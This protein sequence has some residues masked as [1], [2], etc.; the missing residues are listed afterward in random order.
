MTLLGKQIRQRLL[1]GI[2]AMV[3]AFA[4]ALG[5]QADETLSLQAA[6]GKVLATYPS[7]QAARLRADRAQLELQKVEARLG[8]ALNTRA[9]AERD[10]SF[11][12]APVDRGS[13]SVGVSR[14][15]SS[16]G[17][18]SL[19]GGYT[20]EDSSVSISPELPN[21]SETTSID[22][23]YRMPLA[24][25]RGNPAYE[26]D[27]RKA[28]AD[29]A[30]GV[31]E[32]VRERDTI[33]QQVIDLYYAAAFTLARIDNA[34]QAI[35]RSKRLLNFVK[36]NRR[37]GI[38]EEKD[39][40]QAEAQLRAQEAEHD[41]LLAVWEQQRTSLN[42][43]LGI[44]WN[45]EIRPQ[46]PALKGPLGNEADIFSAIL[47]Y[48]PDLR[49]QRARLEQTEAALIKRQ[50]S[51]RDK[52]DLVWSLGA[53]NRSGDTASG[54]VDDSSVVGGLALE[55]QSPLDQ[56]GVD[57]ELKQALLDRDIAK[58]DLQA[59][60]IFAKHDAS[61]LLS[62]I[63]TSRRALDSYEARLLAEQRKLREA[64]R[65]YREG[66]ADT[67]QLVQFEGDLRVTQL[68]LDQQRI[69]LAKRLARLQLLQ[70]HLWAGVTGADRFDTDS[71]GAGTGG[72]S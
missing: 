49:A 61:G 3:L 62:E 34:R 48:H 56:R 28:K 13:L 69:E 19:N 44:P 10:L 71:I 22:L 4:G 6:L 15:L 47:S 67:A 14:P 55:Y 58:Q 27:V 29:Q 16:G 26:Q 46:L 45:Q 64:E 42:S 72:Q 41:A 31:A 12:G 54:E 37:L 23:D 20:Q 1:H 30:M 11:F 63:R 53:R 18:F 36:K 70:G 32:K 43:F 65:R 24:R 50:D 35:V 33:A 59:M 52:L 7:I 25:G 39:Q 38:S 9:S 21:P 68:A 57:A 17:E 60:E 40:L 8:W 66:R 5:V 2:A 51:K